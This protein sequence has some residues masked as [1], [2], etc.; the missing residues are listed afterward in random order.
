MGERRADL[1]ALFTERARRAGAEVQEANPD[2]LL[3]LLR[4]QTEGRRASS[5]AA[6]RELAGEFPDVSSLTSEAPDWPEIVIGG[7]RAAVAET[8][9]VIP[10]AEHHHDRL[11]TLLCA[12]HIVVLRAH[13]ILPGLRSVPP[14][15]RQEMGEGKALYCT[16]VSGPSRTSDIER[17][18]TIG[19]HGPRELTVVLLNEDC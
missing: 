17:V 11:L 14:W 12:V 7:A 18:L 1:I 9:S 6:T 4:L 10:A 19:V 15:L 16:L 13:D 3:S 8:G 2:G 5:V